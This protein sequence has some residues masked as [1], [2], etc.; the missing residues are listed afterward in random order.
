MAKMQS[1]TLLQRRKWDGSDFSGPTEDLLYHTVINSALHVQLPPTKLAQFLLTPRLLQS[2]NGCSAAM[3][4]DII[5]E[6][7]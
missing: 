7:F 2:L 1:Q 3:E 4:R 5:A 6:G